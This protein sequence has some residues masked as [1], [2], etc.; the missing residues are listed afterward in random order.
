MRSVKVEQSNR[1]RKIAHEAVY[2]LQEHLAG[3]ITE[4]YAQSINEINEQLSSVLRSGFAL[5][6]SEIYDQL[7]AFENQLFTQLERSLK[8]EFR[9][10]ANQALMRRFNDIF[11]KDEKGNQRNWVIM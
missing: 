7:S 2:E 3:K 10:Q 11:R 1:L 9:T 4:R 8:D 6:S 5:N